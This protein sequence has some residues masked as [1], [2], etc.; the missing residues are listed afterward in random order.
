MQYDSLNIKNFEWYTD[1]YSPHFTM[2]KW[3]LI[4]KWDYIM[5]GIGYNISCKYF[6]KVMSY[7]DYYYYHHVFIS[8]EIPGVECALGWLYLYHSGAAQV[9]DLPGALDGSLWS[10]AENLTWAEYLALKA[11]NIIDN[12]ALGES[13]PPPSS[14]ECV[15]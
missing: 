5:N 6:S 11:V 10:P 15:I 8:R 13:K 9:R 3:Y 7:K 2:F 4:I 1:V 14:F 12:K